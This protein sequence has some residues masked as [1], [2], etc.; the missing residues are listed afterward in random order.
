METVTISIKQYHLLV[1][2]H[3]SVL[4]NSLLKGNGNLSQESLEIM[5]KLAEFSPE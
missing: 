3:L 4:E 1:D 5:N 2:L